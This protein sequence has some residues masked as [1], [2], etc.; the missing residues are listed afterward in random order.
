M[1]ER[2]LLSLRPTYLL[3]ALFKSQFGLLTSPRGFPGGSVVK[4]PP[5][6]QEL[7]ETRVQSW[8]GKIPWMR[9]WQLTLVFLPG[10]SHGQRSLVGYDPW[11]C[12]ESDTTEATE[13]AHTRV[14]K[15]GTVLYLAVAAPETVN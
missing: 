3:S 14:R 1:T 15:V 5:A 10:E 9:A 2:L 12:K 13:H 6:V 11:G 4:N 8:V 7:Q